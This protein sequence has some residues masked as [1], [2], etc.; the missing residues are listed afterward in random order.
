MKEEIQTGD[1]H[2]RVTGDID[3]MNKIRSVLKR[4]FNI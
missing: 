2:F 1:I 4:K 3:V